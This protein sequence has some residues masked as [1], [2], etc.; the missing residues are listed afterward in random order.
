MNSSTLRRQK[1][2]FLISVANYCSKYE[3]ILKKMEIIKELL[4]ESDDTLLY[5][6]LRDNNEKIVKKIGE[7]LS[8]VEKSKEEAVRKID[9]K[10]MELEEEE[11][12]ER[13]RLEQ[14]RLEKEKLIKTTSDL[15]AQ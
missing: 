13:E 4:E 3:E 11:R 8:E 1:A 9:I 2:D 12:R 14:E 7:L 6:F 10:I 5:Q 15:T